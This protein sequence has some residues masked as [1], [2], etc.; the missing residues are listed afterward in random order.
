MPETH[1]AVEGAFATLDAHAR[2]TPDRSEQCRIKTIYGAEPDLAAVCSCGVRVD[3]ADRVQ[4]DRLFASHVS[5][6]EWEASR[7]D[8]ETSRRGLAAARE[9]LQHTADMKAGGA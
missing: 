1:S 4:L 9:R 8:P 6:V 3:A 7:P 5:E 2:Q